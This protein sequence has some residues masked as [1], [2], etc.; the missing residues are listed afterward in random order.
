MPPGPTPA[1]GPVCKSGL[2]QLRG[3]PVVNEACKIR[4]L[5]LQA[6]FLFWPICL[7]ALGRSRCFG[8]SPRLTPSLGS[9]VKPFLTP[10]LQHEWAVLFLSGVG[11]CDP[12]GNLRKQHELHGESVRVPAG[13]EGRATGGLGFL[14]LGQRLSNLCAHSNKGT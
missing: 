2:S 14:L 5:S 1:T 13:R 3:S 7:L 8:L 10:R 11:C 4:S 6:S 9:D 12:G